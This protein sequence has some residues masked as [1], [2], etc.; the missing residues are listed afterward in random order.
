MAFNTNIP[1]ACLISAKGVN[2]KIWG[3]A[4]IHPLLHENNGQ[5]EQTIV[6]IINLSMQ[7]FFNLEC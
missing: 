6:K 4:F 7:Q 5:K 1:N 2:H 3:P